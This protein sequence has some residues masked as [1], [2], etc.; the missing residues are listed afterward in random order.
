MASTPDKDE[1]PKNPDKEFGE[2]NYKATRDYN[3]RTQ[4]FVKSGKV[5]EAANAARPRDR[6]EEQD[7]ARAEDIGRSHAKGESK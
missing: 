1:A 6:K 2:G 5:E 4:R 7:M 3:E